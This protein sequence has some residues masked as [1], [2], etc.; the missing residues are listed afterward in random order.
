MPTSGCN[1]AFSLGKYFFCFFL[2]CFVLFFFGGG[3][4]GIGGGGVS[5]PSLWHRKLKLRLIKVL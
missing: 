3:G 4:G 1:A 2:F 5:F